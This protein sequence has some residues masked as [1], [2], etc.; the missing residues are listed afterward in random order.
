VTSQQL[1]D[2]NSIGSKPTAGPRRSRS[3]LQPRVVDV[4]RDPLQVECV[5]KD[6]YYLQNWSLTFDVRI[7]VVDPRQLHVADQVPVA[8]DRYR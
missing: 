2:R 7:I 6:L 5:E 1:H 4:G 8:F 3:L